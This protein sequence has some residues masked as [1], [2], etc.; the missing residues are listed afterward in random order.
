MM[1]GSPR[2]IAIDDQPD[3]LQGLA[4]CLNQQGIACLRIHFTGDPADVQVCPDVRIIFADLHLGMGSPSD[5][6]SNF[7][8]I[9]GLLRDTIKPS[10]PY[11]IILWT[12]FPE[13]AEAL[14]TFLDRPDTD[15]AKP[16]D[17]QPLAK[18]D[19]LDPHGRVK[20]EEVLIEAI[21]GI[22]GDSP[23]LASLFDWEGWVLAATGRTVS[24]IL[25]LA[26]AE[27]TAERA[28]E[29]GKILSRLAIEAVGANNV[30]TD[31]FRAVN[32]ALLP[33]LADRISALRSGVPQQEIWSKALEPVAGLPGL[34]LENAARLNSLVH[35]AEPETAAAAERGVVVCLPRRYRRRFDRCFGLSEQDAAA[36][37]FRCTQFAEADDQFCWVLVQCEASCDHAQANPGTLPFYLGL[38]FPARRRHKRKKPPASTWRGPPFDLDGHARVLRVS[39]RFP[40]ALPRSYARNATPLFRLREQIL[41]QLTY[42]IHTH[43]ARPGMIA[44]RDK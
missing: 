34:S 18:A 27:G 40:V 30:E 22:V 23:Q 33:I 14:R 8:M 16:F 21:K 44:F 11:F 41:N 17:V 20:D 28:K 29:V 12:Q 37:E 38:V 9:G 19:H 5:H 1:L 24:S 25:D 31:P 10:G 26:A 35:I 39:A 4:D 7:S 6:K 2:I 15:V 43:G 3:H 42:H 36:K 13:Q 32:E